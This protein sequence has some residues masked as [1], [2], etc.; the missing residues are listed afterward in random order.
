LHPVALSPGDIRSSDVL[1]GRADL[2]SALK[3]IK[4]QL[5]SARDGGIGYG[6]L[7]CLNQETAS[8]LADCSE[9]E[10]LFNYLGHLTGTA[11]PGDPAAWSLAAESRLVADGADP[12]MPLRHA[13]TIDAGIFAGELTATWSWAPSCCEYTA[14]AKLADRWVE[15]LVAFAG[16]ESIGGFTPTDLLIDLDQKDIDALEEMW[17]TLS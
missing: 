17:G 6:M 11:E 7:R 8:R 12:H 3:R 10:V 5:R 16:D 14:I 13:L 2:N 9:P 4:E 15:I 1:A